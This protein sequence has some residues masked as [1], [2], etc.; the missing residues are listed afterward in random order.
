MWAPFRFRRF[1]GA[2]E[3][4]SMQ[5]EREIGK[6]VYL[7]EGHKW[8]AQEAWP[9]GNTTVGATCMQVDS[10]DAKRIVWITPC[11][12]RGLFSNSFFSQ[13]SLIC[14]RRS[15]PGWPKYTLASSSLRIGCVGVWN[16]HG[17]EGVFLLF[18]SCCALSV[19]V[20]VCV[21]VCTWA[22]A[23]AMQ[24]DSHGQLFCS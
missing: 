2:E 3:I 11:M 7:E 1:K 17:L 15:S 21:H 23:R 8:D 13:H 5:G 24:R 4:L 19:Y 10:E 14:W 6:E 20:W 16:M 12:R 18:Y 9:R 22:I